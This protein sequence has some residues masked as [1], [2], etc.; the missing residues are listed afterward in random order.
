[1]NENIKSTIQNLVNDGLCTGCGTCVGLC[2]RSALTIFKENSKGIYIPRL[3]VSCCS[4]CGTCLNVCPGRDVDF[5]RL[6]LE[7][8]GE[9]PKDSLIGNYLNCYSGWA[10]DEDLRFKAASGGL[11]TQ[12]LIF[13]FEQKIIDG[14]LLVKMDDKK[15]FEPKPFIARTKE[16]LMDASTSKY[17]PVPL[18]VILN[19]IIES[20]KEKFAVVGLPCHIHGFRKAETFNEE[21]RNKIVLHMG[22]M[23][24]TTKNFHGTAFQLNRMDINKKN[25]TKIHYRGNGWPGDLGICLKNGEM[26]NELYMKYYDFNFCAFTPWRCMLCPDHTC[27]LADLSFGDAWLK[28]FSHDNLGTSI[29]ISRNSIGEKIL[30]KALNEN[31]IK[32]NELDPSKVSLSQNMCRFKKN[33]LKARIKIAKIFRMRIPKYNLDLLD[34]SI[35][36]YFW[37]IYFYVLYF[38]SSKKRL[39]PLLDVQGLIINLIKKIRKRKL[40]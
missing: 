17:C 40:R 29:V 28:E 16:E 39:W 37:A 15:P 11:V 30:Q 9:T 25:V 21:L 12:I 4:N 14:A 2:P 33:Q 34:S 7:I 22:I 24:G 36:D 23:C 26:I 20:Q 1:M 31:Y 8:F 32:L 5:K 10:T 3:D 6:N 19:E 18:N 35:K 13:L 27:E 38:I